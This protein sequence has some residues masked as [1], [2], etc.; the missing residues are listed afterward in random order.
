MT[1]ENVYFGKQLY[2]TNPLKYHIEEY[3]PYTIVIYD[4][5]AQYIAYTQG[6]ALM[7][8]WN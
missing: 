4:S 7:L 2:S 1:F 5:A 3:P 6:K 8:S